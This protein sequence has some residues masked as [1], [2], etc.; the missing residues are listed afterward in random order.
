MKEHI[1]AEPP[2]IEDTIAVVWGTWEKGKRKA[3]LLER[4]GRIELL[5]YISLTIITAKALGVPTDHAFELM[6]HVM[7]A[8]VLLHTP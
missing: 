5:L 6:K 8:A 2:S 7:P 1:S 4:M 3:G